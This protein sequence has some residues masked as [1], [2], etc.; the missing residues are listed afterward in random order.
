MRQTSKRHRNL[1]LEC[2]QAD[3]VS[4]NKLKKLHRLS[5]GALDRK[6]EALT[7]RVRSYSARLTSLL[8]WKPEREW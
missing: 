1:D 3:N 7:L 6:H 4:S 2:E 5:F 8:L